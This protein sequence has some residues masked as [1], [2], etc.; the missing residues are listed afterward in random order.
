MRKMKFNI[1]MLLI[2]FNVGYS[3]AQDEK[4]EGGDDRNVMLNAAS[5]NAGPRNVNIGLPASVGGTTVLENDL[6]VVYFYWPE[7][8]FKSWRMDAMTNGVKLMDL[9]QTAIN[10]GDVGFSVGTYNNL[11]TDQVQGTGSFTSN[12]FGLVKTDVN[13][14]GPIADGWKFSLGAFLN[15]DPSTYSA[16]A[17]GIDKFFNDRTQLYKIA[18]TKD[19]KFGSGSGSISAFYKYAKSES[20]TLR[21]YAPFR[22]HADG[23]VSELDGFKIGTTNYIATQKVMLKSAETGELRSQDAL[24]DFGSES[25]TLDFIG[26]NNFDNGL[27]FNYIVRGHSAESGLYLPIM[28]GITG[29]T[30]GVMILASRK[31]PNKLPRSR[32]DEVLLTRR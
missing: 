32:A 9:G 26:K 1:L 22:Y 20:M 28:T 24:N 13:V 12:S 6:P 15:Y 3:I 31:T 8:P 19:Y 25:H 11:G 5:A 29:N 23:S 30:Q 16:N 7:M 18:L 17:N 27:A 10:V 21:E 2:I 14:S 4:K